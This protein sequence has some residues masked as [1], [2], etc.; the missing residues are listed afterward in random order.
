MRQAIWVRTVRERRVAILVW[1]VGLGALIGLTLAYGAGLGAEARLAQAAI[2][3]TMPFRGD[4]VAVETPEG[5]ATWH[6][7]GLLPPLLAI[8]AVLAGAD[9]VRGEEERG[10]LDLVLATPHARWRVLAEKLAGLGVAGLLIAALTGLGVVAGEGFGG[11]AVDV[12]GAVLT[13]INIGLAA[14]VYGLLALVLAQFLARRVTV[15]LAGALLA[16]GYLLDASSRTLAGAGWLGR[17]S[18]F[19]YHNLSKPLVPEAG[20]N[21]GALA[22]LALADMALAA[23]ALALFQ[24]R[25]VGTTVLWTRPRSTRAR[26]RTGGREELATAW[27]HWSVRGVWWRAL[28]AESAPLVWWVLALAASTAWI[29]LL[30]RTLSRSIAD[31]IATTPALAALFRDF[32]IGTDTGFLGGVLLFYLPALLTLQALTAALAWAGDLEGGR[33]ELVLA[34]ARPHWRILLERAAIVPLGAAA[35][36]LA[37]WAAM[38]ATARLAGMDID[39]GRL[40]VA[41]LGLVPLALLTGA[42]AYALS[43]W[44]RSGGVVAVCGALLAVSYFADVLNPLLELPGWALA[45]SIFHQYGRPVTEDPRW[46][47]WLVLTALA[48]GLMALGVA[49]FARADI[50]HGT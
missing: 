40:T 8:W 13:G 9:I 33:L 3:R 30:A 11:L 39:A 37:S 36:P 50:D 42:A 34:T 10:V 4:P 35:L 7:V 19:Y 16:A 21:A 49:R 23:L 31:M 46:Q 1:G 38:L 29:T 12:G 17:L 32:A 27:R 22:G 25:D 44:L 5:Y 6:T 41:Y 28:R 2:A 14:L 45:L 26:Q 15:A 48:V 20:V 24:R 47:A 43:G 18:P